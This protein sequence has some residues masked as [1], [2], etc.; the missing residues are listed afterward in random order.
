MYLKYKMIFDDQDGQHS[1]VDLVMFLMVSRSATSRHHQAT[2]QPSG[3]PHGAKRTD[4]I[5]LWLPGDS[6]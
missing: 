2:R 4:W 3:F 5:E 1:Y 6:T